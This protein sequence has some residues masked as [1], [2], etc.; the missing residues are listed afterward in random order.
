MDLYFASVLDHE[1]VGRFLAPHKIRHG[2]RN[3]AYPL[4]EQRL[5]GLVAQSH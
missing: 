1:T 3:T 4:V 5:F 2:P